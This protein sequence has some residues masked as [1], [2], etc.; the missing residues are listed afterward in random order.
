MTNEKVKAK[1]F[2]VPQVCESLKYP[3]FVK[4][5]NKKE[6]FVEVV[7]FFFFEKHQNKNYTDSVTNLIAYSGGIRANISI[8]IYFFLVFIFL[9]IIVNASDEQGKR[10]YPDIKKIKL[11]YQESW[12]FVVEINY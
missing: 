6:A 10:F 1:I 7:Q 12:D 3:N 9:K 8:K 5:I 4:T 11:Y 2:D